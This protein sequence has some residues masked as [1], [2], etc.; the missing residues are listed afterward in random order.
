MATDQDSCFDIRDCRQLSDIIMGCAAT[1]FACIWAA[2]HRDIP[3]PNRSWYFA[4]WSPIGLT[5]RALLIP[6]FMIGLAMQQFI[7]AGEIAEELES[8]AQARVDAES[9]DG[10]EETQSHGT[11]SV[12]DRVT[13]ALRWSGLF[14]MGMK[15]NSVGS[16]LMQTTGWMRSRYVEISTPKRIPKG[17]QCTRTHGYFV[18]MGGFYLYEGHSPIRRLSRE[19]VVDLVK[20]DLLLPPTEAEINDKS[21]GD[22]VTKGVALLQIMWFLTQCIARTIQGLPITEFE[23][24]TAAYTTIAICCYIFWWKKP[25]GVGQ[26]IRVFHE[27]NTSNN[28]DPDAFARGFAMVGPSVWCL[29]VSTARP[30]NGLTP[31]ERS[32]E[33]PR[34]SSLGYL[35]GLGLVWLVY[36]VALVLVGYK[37]LVKYWVLYPV[38]VASNFVISGYAFARITLLTLVVMSLTDIP[39]PVYKSVDWVAL[40]PHI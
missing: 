38:A 6:E 8:L 10:L 12:D 33:Y 7:M 40:I 17:P 23:L 34:E 4:L 29:E 24:V 19:D 1:I 18:L 31:T 21:K 26:P 5:L 2:D 20:R 16:I 25:L 14:R 11:V 3:D 32:G 13:R 27:P 28:E 35:P 37:T 36:G 22:W 30:G 9:F 15:E 39:P